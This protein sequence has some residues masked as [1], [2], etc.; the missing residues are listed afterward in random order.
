MEIIDALQPRRTKS[1]PERTRLFFGLDVNVT[2]AARGGVE[3]KGR[4]GRSSANHVPRLSLDRQQ[5]SSPIGRR[6]SF[7]ATE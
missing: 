4:S 5:A 6:S 2:A 3:V 7:S 1:T